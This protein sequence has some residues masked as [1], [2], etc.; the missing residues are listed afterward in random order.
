MKKA[1]IILIFLFL[2]SHVA[3]ITIGSFPF[4]KQKDSKSLNMSFRLGLINPGNQEV[5]IGLSAPQDQNYSV[6]F[7]ENRLTLSPSELSGN[8]SGSNWYYIGNGKYAE[9]R[10]VDFNVDISPYRDSNK[11]RIPVNVQA[12]IDS[13]DNSSTASRIVYVQQ[14]SFQANLHPSL[15]PLNR[16]DDEPDEETWRDRYWQEEN[17]D[18]FGSEDSRDLEDPD[19]HNL[20]QNSATNLSKDYKASET[21]ESTGEK[22]IDGTTL[23]LIAGI[24]AAAG[25]IFKVI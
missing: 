8:P 23:V 18:N 24:L 7:P 9:I 16:P 10:Y 13:E 19:K 5:Q 11:L 21:D 4:Q 22:G 2:G 1:A 12:S 3:A 6:E 20:D 14:H 25:Y 15:D 17:S